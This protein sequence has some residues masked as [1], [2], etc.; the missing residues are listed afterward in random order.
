MLPF[1]IHER[2]ISVFMRAF[3][4]LCFQYSSCVVVEVK[5]MVFQYSAFSRDL[6]KP[7]MCTNKPLNFFDK[8]TGVKSIYLFFDAII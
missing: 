2:G 4:S 7:K 3:E 1:I 6:P 8:G 5:T